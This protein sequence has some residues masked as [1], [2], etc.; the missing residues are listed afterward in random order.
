MSTNIFFTSDT[1]F[2]HS[3]ILEHEPERRPFDTIEQHDNFIIESWN[4]VVRPTS[5]VYHLGDFSFRSTHHVGWYLNKLKGKIILI[6]GN[7]DDHGK[8][9]AWDQRHLFESAHEAL[10]IKINKVKIYLLHYSCR[11]WRSSH[12]GSFHL[13]G[14]SHGALPELGRSMDVCI[15][16]N[17][18]RPFS[19]EQVYENLSN[20]GYTDHHPEHAE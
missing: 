7:H 18:Y 4:S 15:A 1:H 19:F 12:H 6:R 5:T 14:H 10:Y 17:G 11:V 9:C 8:N 3:K 13:H 16:L 20:R 2:G